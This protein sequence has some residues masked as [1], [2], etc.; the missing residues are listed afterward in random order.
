MHLTIVGK[1]SAASSG[2]DFQ[3]STTKQFPSIKMTASVD[4]R[5]RTTNPTLELYMW[6]K[7][8]KPVK[9]KHRDKMWQ[10]KGGIHMVGS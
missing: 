5:S 6:L 10:V 1:C 8:L 2:V 3:T 9:Y 7:Y 4:I